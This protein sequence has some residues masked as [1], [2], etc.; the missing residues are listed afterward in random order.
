MLFRSVSK[1]RKSGSPSSFSPCSALSNPC[2]TPRSPLCPALSSLPLRSQEARALACRRPRRARPHQAKLE[3]APPGSP[4]SRAQPPPQ[5]TRHP[6]VIV[7]PIPAPAPSTRGR[8]MD[9]TRIV[10]RHRPR[11]HT[12]G[13]LASTVI[14]HHH[15]ALAAAFSRPIAA[16]LGSCRRR[17]PGSRHGRHQL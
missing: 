4:T 16:V 6:S 1:N 11:H 15:T 5:P 8:T 3:A 10:L 13:S 9:A 2:L 7:S 14:C 17:P 12:I